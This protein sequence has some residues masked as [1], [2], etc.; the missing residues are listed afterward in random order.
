MDEFAAILHI[1][2]APLGSVRFGIAESDQTLIRPQAERC[3][4][5]LMASRWEEADHQEQRK[6]RKLAWQKPNSAFRVWTMRSPE[7]QRSHRHVI[8]EFVAWCCS[9][10]RLSFDKTVVP[11][12]RIHLA[13]RRAGDGNHECEARLRAQAGRRGGWLPAC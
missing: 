7:S 13:D 1:G 2:T 10:P 4:R 12:Y 8:D 11:R 9:E 3:C 6:K 5:I